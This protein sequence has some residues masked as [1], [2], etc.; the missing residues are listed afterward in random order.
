MASAPALLFRNSPQEIAANFAESGKI[1]ILAT[2]MTWVIGNLADCHPLE[3][4]ANTLRTPAPVT[5]YATRSYGTDEERK[6]LDEDDLNEVEGTVPVKDKKE[7]DL[8][9]VLLPLDR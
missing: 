7:R 2:Q 6:V 9:R 5:G 3:I 8:K 4:F 1:T